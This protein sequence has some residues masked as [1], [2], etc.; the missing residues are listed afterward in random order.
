VQLEA[1]A[2][3]AAAQRLRAEG[4]LLL[5][6]VGV[7]YLHYPE[8]QPE[9]F[10]AIYNFY[11]V[12][13]AERIFLRIPLADGAAVPS[14]AG[15]WRSAMYLE[16]EVFDLFGIAFEGHPDLRKIL[17]PDDLE[18]YPLR[19]DFPLGETP[20]L[21]NEGRFLDPA[22]FRAGLS[23]SQAGLTGWKGGDRKGVGAP[24]PQGLRRPS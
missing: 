10:C 9:R 15:L 12:D 8:A 21:F 3:L 11:Q 24:A 2:L 16:R 22:A 5:D 7:D 23:G 14:L 19:K 1:G 6:I 20:T 18:G 17:T 13:Q 4:Y